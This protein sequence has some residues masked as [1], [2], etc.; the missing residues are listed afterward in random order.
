MK[1]DLIKL[2]QPTISKNGKYA[3]IPCV[4]KEGKFYTAIVPIKEQTRGISAYTD[5]VC[6]T[7]LLDVKELKQ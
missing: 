6:L 4:T 5:N 3:L 1:N 7:L 2:C